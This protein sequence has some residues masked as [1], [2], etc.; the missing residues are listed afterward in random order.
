MAA[1]EDPVLTEIQMAE[2]SALADGT[3][4]ADRKASV[5]ALLASSP[6]IRQYYE[7][8]R[9]L[10]E[11]LHAARTTDRAPLALRERIESDRARAGRTRARRWRPAAWPAAGLGGALAALAAVLLIGS[12]SSVPPM[13]AATAKLAE[14]GAVAGAPSATPSNPAELT[15]NV[16]GLHFP[17]TL[18]REAPLHVVGVRTDRFAG[19]QVVTVYYA[20]HGKSVAYSI[21]AP[22]PVHQPATWERNSSPYYTFTLGGRHV[23]VWQYKHHTCVLSSRQITSE[24]LNLLV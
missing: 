22:P 18:G 4:P 24:G 14:R 11:R 8:E 12:S 15:T 19:R 9:R 16:V 6:E 5:D 21:M 23:L 1:K 7:R 3:L 2:L 13:V 17:A 10:V 20:G